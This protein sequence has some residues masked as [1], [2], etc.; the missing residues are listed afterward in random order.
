MGVAGT[1]LVFTFQP[2]VAFEKLHTFHEK[3]PLS[4]TGSMQLR[5]FNFPPFKKHKQSKQT[6][7]TT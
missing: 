7:K 5:Q 1:S 6:K 4:S 3:V 2:N